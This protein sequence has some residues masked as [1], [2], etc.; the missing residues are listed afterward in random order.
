MC[1]ECLGGGLV[2]RGG[3]LAG[4]KIEDFGEVKE[5]PISKEDDKCMSVK[6]C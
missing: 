2:V 4:R 6:C 5:K 1:G 3:A